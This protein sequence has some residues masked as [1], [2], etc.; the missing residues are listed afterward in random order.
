MWMRRRTSGTSGSRGTGSVVTPADAPARRMRK[1]RLMLKRRLLVP[2]LLTF[3]AAAA[4]AGAQD[5]LPTP[6]PAPPPP[7]PPPAAAKLTIK[8]EKT[9]GPAKHAFALRGDHVRVTGVLSPPAAG[10][11]VIVRVYRKRHKLRARKVT[12]RPDGTFATRFRASGHVRL[13]VRAVHRASP[14]LGTARARAR[15]VYVVRPHLYPGSSG[16]LVKVFQRALARLHYVTPRDGVYGAATERAVMAYRKVNFRPRTFDADERVIRRVLAGRGAW[17][18]RHPGLGHHV[19][20][21]L[22]QQVLSLIDG[23]RVAH[24]YMTSS[25]KPS[26]PTI[27]GTFHV[28]SK[29]PGTN[30]LGMVDTSY[31]RG[32]YGIHGYISVPAY[33]ASHGCLRVPVPDAP[34]IYR[35]IQM[36]DAVVVEA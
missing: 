18:V 3:L 20:A 7:P 21:D 27:R 30:T 22:S 6:T 8:L 9:R 14:A 15:H 2:T 36:G 25:G 28:Y 4:P 19:E 32:G 35:W 11:K 5:P 23:K 34:S 24:T 12:V 17:K 10:E 26:T 13:T 31:F 29:T 16:L 1:F 33:A